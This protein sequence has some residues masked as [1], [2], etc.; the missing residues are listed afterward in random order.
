[1]EPPLIVDKDDSKW[2]LLAG[3]LKI[4]DSRRVK[5]AISYPL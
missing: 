1:M 3:V 2:K 5:L 4:F